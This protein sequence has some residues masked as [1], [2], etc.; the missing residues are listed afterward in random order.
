MKSAFVALTVC[1]LIAVDC[2]NNMSRPSSRKAYIVFEG[3]VLKV[4][5]PVAV[6]GRISAYRLVK[7]R[8]E[9][10]CRGKYGK[11]DIV[12]DHLI[13]TGKELEG[14][15]VGHRVWLTVDKVKK[16]SPQYNAEGIRDKSEAVADFYIARTLGQIPP[17]ACSL[18]R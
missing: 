15:E 6:S 8:V 2:P 16:I 4:S 12:V 10:V 9:K 13:L 14:L 7:Y 1:A 18:N 3:T 5:P 11:A 17:S